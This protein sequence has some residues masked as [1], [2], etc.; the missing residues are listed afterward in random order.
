MS[1]SAGEAGQMTPKAGAVSHV[2]IVL[3]ARPLERVDSEIAVTGFFTDE[4]PL[5]GGAARADWRLCGGLSRRIENG[6]L[7]GNSGE[8]MLIACGRALRAPR[9][10]LLGLGDRQTYDQLRVSD[11]IRSALDRCRKLRL[12]EVVLTPLGIASDDVPR[13]RAARRALKVLPSQ[14]MMPAST[15]SDPPSISPAPL[16]K[17]KPRAGEARTRRQSVRHAQGVCS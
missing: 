13:V 3:T 5:R 12:Q 2:E 9:L 16:T 11:E 4:R 15:G 8:A 6:D 14:R 17:R 1:A 7:S 10:M